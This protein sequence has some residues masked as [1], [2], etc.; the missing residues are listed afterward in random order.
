MKGRRGPNALV[1][2]CIS[3]HFFLFLQEG[4]SLCFFFR[5]PGLHIMLLLVF[6]SWP[7]V[8]QRERLIST[9]K[10]EEASLIGLGGSGEIE[11]L[12]GFEG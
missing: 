12:G 10:R 11:E 6:L 4:Q 7:K 9:E 8:R 3:L 2:S 1:S 5:L